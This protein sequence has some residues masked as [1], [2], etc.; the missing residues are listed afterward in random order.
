MKSLSLSF[1]QLGQYENVEY[2]LRDA[3]GNV[4][5]VFQEYR[6]TQ[7]LIKKGIISP[8]WIN[9]RAVNLISPFLGYWSSSKKVR[10]LVT[11]A[12]KAGAAGRLMGSGAPAAFT[13]IAVGT[14][15]TA[16]NVADTTLQTETATSGLSRAN[17]TVSLVTTTVTNDTAQ[18]TNTFTVTGTVAVTESGVLNA[19]AAG[20]LLTR[21]VFTAI[22]VVNG[23]SLAITWKVQMS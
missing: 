9:S 10:N 2:V 17:G 12:G 4:K 22:N 11:T 21:Q 3:Q 14:G 20:T 19:A 7:F 5:P 8:L 6:L 18:V 23:D 15:A 13:Y 16:A 1:A